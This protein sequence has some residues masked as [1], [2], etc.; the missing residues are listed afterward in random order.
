[1]AGMRGVNQRQMKQAMKKMGI[2]NEQIAN[3]TEVIIKTTDKEIVILNPT[4]NAM[5]IQ[6]QK[7]FQIDGET[8]ERPLGSSESA[9]T[10]PFT[11]EDVELVM[12]QTSCSKEKA[13]E[14]LEAC[15]GQLAEAIM[16]I[17]TE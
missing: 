9:P 10:L 11:A 7:S 3:V 12:S 1:M 14:A 8:I 5:S 15:D 2:T 16:K 13:V 4:V 6:G 17:M